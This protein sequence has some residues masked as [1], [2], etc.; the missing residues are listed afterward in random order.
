M[1]YF[2]LFS[3]FIYSA[4]FIELNAQVTTG[5]SY[6]ISQLS[7]ESVTILQEPVVNEF[8]EIGDTSFTSYQ[9]CSVPFDTY[10]VNGAQ[11]DNI[12][13]PNPTG[14]YLN[15]Q[16]FTYFCGIEMSIRQNFNNILQV[17]EFSYLSSKYLMIINFREDCMGDGCKYRCYNL[18]DITFPEKIIQISFSSVFEGTETFGEFNSDGV[19][20]FLRVAPKPDKDGNGD[21]FENYLLTAYT[22]PRKTAKQLTNI[23]K[24]AYYLYV[25]G[26]EEARN[27]QVLQADWFFSMKDTSGNVAEKKSYFAPYISF[28]PL[29][30]YL[31]S[32]EGIRIE[33]NRWSVFIED[34]GDLQAAQDFCAKIRAKK[35]G[36]PYIMIDQYSN[37][38]KFQ[39]FVGNY[40]SKKT[41]EQYLSVLTEKGI[42]GALRD[43]R[44]AY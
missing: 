28:D 13:N 32:P 44:K 3:C 8:R 7:Q 23:E 20:D 29:Y 11:Y 10:F 40:V 17:K 39:A 30:K 22:I 42:K 43:L 18:F 36:D 34:F 9:N 19:I 25:R 24:Q 38:I 5:V 41:A 37:D 26:D 14:L 1:K 6:N 4:I 16:H 27:F 31:Y 21:G 35:L 15:K 33:K 2:I 12:F